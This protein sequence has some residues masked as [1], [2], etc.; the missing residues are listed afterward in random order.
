[1][2]FKNTTTGVILEPKCD[3]V[4]EQLEKS[5]DYAP[6]DG[7]DDAQ[8]GQKSLSKMNKDELLAAAQAAGIVV[9]DGAKKDEIIEL[10]QAN[11]GNQ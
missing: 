8:N 1:M 3:M 9:P 5:P 6:Y 10:I 4:R 11:S 7:Q 2:K